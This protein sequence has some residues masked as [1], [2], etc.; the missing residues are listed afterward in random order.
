MM[1]ALYGSEDFSETE[2]EKI[3]LLM[4]TYLADYYQQVQ[5]ISSDDTNDSEDA[6]ATESVLTAAKNLLEKI[7]TLSDST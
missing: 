6:I 7:D 5:K 3:L 1:Q 4:S 2:R